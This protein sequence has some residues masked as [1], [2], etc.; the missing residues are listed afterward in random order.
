MQNLD[1]SY[2]SDSDVS[3]QIT[4]LAGGRNKGGGEKSVSSF[5]RLNDSKQNQSISSSSS[6][7]NSQE[8]G[9]IAIPKARPARRLSVV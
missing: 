5:K 7:S 3:N 4:N 2:D 8:S 1:F 9:H 6:S